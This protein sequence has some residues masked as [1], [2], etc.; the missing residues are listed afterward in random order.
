MILTQLACSSS[1][2]GFYLSGFGLAELR[3]FWELKS[4]Q[5]C[6]SG[7]DTE[8]FLWNLSDCDSPGATHRGTCS[9]CT[10]RGIICL[11]G[12]MFHCAL[13]SS[14]SFLPIPLNHCPSESSYS[15]TPLHTP[16]LPISVSIHLLCLPVPPSPLCS[17]LFLLS[18][19]CFSICLSFV[20]CFLTFSVCVSL[21]NTSFSG[22][23]GA[24]DNLFLL[25]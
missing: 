25:F 11:Q 5:P 8:R 4:V 16:P 15:L 6:T 19:S 23:P 12:D 21:C 2:R 14:R 17:I 24:S 10:A 1:E 9:L 7:V 13:A 22:F 20:S 3:L 18:M